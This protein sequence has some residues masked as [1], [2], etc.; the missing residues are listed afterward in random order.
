MVL[1]GAPRDAVGALPCKSRPQAQTVGQRKGKQTTLKYVHSYAIVDDPV[2]RVWLARWRGL[3]LW[4]PQ[5]RPRNKAAPKALLC[6]AE[7]SH[8]GHQAAQAQPGAH[9]ARARPAGA[10]AAAG[11]RAHAGPRAAPTAAAEAA[12]R[13]QGRHLG[14]QHSPLDGRQDAGVAA[15]RQKGAPLPCSPARAEWWQSCTSREASRAA[16]V[17]DGRALQVLSFRGYSLERVLYSPL[18]EVRVRRFEV[19]YYLEDGSVEVVEPT[20]LNSGLPQGVYLHRH[21]CVRLVDLLNRGVGCS[22]PWAAWR[23]SAPEHDPARTMR[24]LRAAGV[25]AN[26]AQGQVGG[27]VAS[28]AQLA[29]RGR[30]ADPVRAHLPPHVVRRQHAPPV[31]AA[32]HAGRPP[33]ARPAHA[34]GAVRREAQGAEGC[35]GRGPPQGGR[36][37]ESRRNPSLAPALLS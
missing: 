7:A 4:R 23:G 10:A 35:D 25:G 8:R 14:R 22:P 18:E 32:A 37:A 9:G 16:H 11:E 26:R 21:K 27:R 1:R 28:A 5:Q 36:A 2:V 30:G 15:L 19:R 29:A 17:H 12:E 33:G 31:R 20:E 24:R 34:P 13:R 6:C 3:L